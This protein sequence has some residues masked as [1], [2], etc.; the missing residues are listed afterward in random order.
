[1]TS[2]EAVSPDQPA[3]NE[4]QTLPPTTFI[5]PPTILLEDGPLL[6][7]NKPAGLLTQGVPTGLPTL[8]AWVRAEI[9]QRYAKPGNVYLGIPHRLDRPVSGVIAFARN[10]KAAAR[11]AEE[12]RER[13]VRKIYW[14][15]VEGT[16]VEP[17]GRLE[18]WLLKDAAAAHVTVVTPEAPGAKQALLDYRV[19][20]TADG[21]SL[22]EVQLL[23]GRMHQI[24]VQCAAVGWPVI[25]DTEYSPVDP[26]QQTTTTTPSTSSVTSHEPRQPPVRI[27]LHARE[28]SLRHPIRFDPVTII[29]DVPA[30]WQPFA[31]L[32]AAAGYPL[33][34]AS[35]VEPAD[36]NVVTT[37]IAE[38]TP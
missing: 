22:L 21:R 24:R 17:S 12:F 23:T 25:G 34:A 38:A 37:P 10:S 30:H 32:L 14:A 2:N 28:L 5:E 19:L 1:M 29:A 4:P 20:A 33:R 26:A 35:P 11:L 7:I 13:R 27:A 18:H 36:G 16:P 9:R 3:P 8:E 15:V 6:A 31:E